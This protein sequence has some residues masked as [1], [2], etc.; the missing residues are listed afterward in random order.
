MEHPKYHIYIKY[1]QESKNSAIRFNLSEEEIVRTFVTPYK[2]GKSFWFCG[3]LL[4]PEKVVDVII[5]RSYEDGGAL[6]LPN[7]EMVAG[8]PDKEFVMEKICMGKV[9]GVSVCTEK[10]LAQKQKTNTISEKE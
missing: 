2:E 10:F 3:N 1:V 5:F 9:K 7:R 4:R 6:V 8:H